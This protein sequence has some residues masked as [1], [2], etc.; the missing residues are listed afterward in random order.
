[1]TEILVSGPNDRSRAAKN[2]ES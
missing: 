2:Q 1:M